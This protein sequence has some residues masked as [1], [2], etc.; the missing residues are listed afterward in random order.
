MLH[1]LLLLLLPDIVMTSSR[2]LPPPPPPRRRDSQ[3]LNIRLCPQQRMPTVGLTVRCS[4][5]RLT[6]IPAGLSNRTTR[7]FLDHNL[8]TSLSSGSFAHLRLLAELDLSH[9]QLSFLE[10]GCFSGLAASLR[11]LDLSSNQL[12]ALDPAVFSGLK[13]HANLT[14]NIWNCDCSMQMSMTQLD[15]D[16]SSL[17]EV[18]CRT[19]DLPNL[20]AVGVS[21]VS[22][23]EDWDLCGSVKRSPDVL[24]LVT[25]LL[26]FLGLLLCFFYYIHQNTVVARRHFDYLQFLQTRE[27]FHMFSPQ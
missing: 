23:V 3:V 10:A 16:F 26:W 5:L 6:K 1:L 20:G 13:V 21:L 17:E 19:S 11:H 4:N 8:I 12:S 2:R 24:S 27:L 15:L 7:L 22:L 9:N 14:L 18:I 25:M